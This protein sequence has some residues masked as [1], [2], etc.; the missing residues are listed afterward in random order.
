MRHDLAAVNDQVKMLGE[1]FVKRREE[2]LYIY[3]LYDSERMRL[4]RR[5][6]ELEAEVEEVYVASSIRWLI[7]GL[8]D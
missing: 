7:C 1:A 5:V 3:S 4:R 8:T 2:T 6:A